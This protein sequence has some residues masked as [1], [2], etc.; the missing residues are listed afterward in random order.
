MKLNLRYNLQESHLI[1]NF[2]LQYRIN[3][4]FTVLLCLIS[5]SVNCKPRH[6]AFIWKKRKRPFL[7]CAGVTTWTQGE[8]IGGNVQSLE[9]LNCNLAD[10]RMDHVTAA[11][12]PSTLLSV[13]VALTLRSATCCSATDFPPAGSSPRAPGPQTAGGIV[14]FELWTQRPKLDSVR[15]GDMGYKW[16]AGNFKLLAFC[17]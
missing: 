10:L 5:W 14:N 16:I 1:F 3:Q 13:G 11:R 2:W 12:G 17:I 15:M 4:G 7:M 6:W 9:E 8:L